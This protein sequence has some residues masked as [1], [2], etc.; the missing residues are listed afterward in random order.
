MSIL[1]LFKTPKIHA[2]NNHTL[3]CVGNHDNGK[4]ASYVCVL[5]VDND[6]VWS[7]TNILHNETYRT[8]TYVGIMKGLKIAEKLKMKNL[9]I[10]TDSGDIVQHLSSPDICK[11][12]KYD[13]YDAT[14]EL[15]VTRFDNVFF[16]KMQPSLVAKYKQSTKEYMDEYKQQIHQEKEQMINKLYFYEL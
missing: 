1:N 10:E 5:L 9:T 4:Y 15:I 11:S 14:V 7:E 13:S 6:V 12:L 3:L 8:A 16:K 2:I